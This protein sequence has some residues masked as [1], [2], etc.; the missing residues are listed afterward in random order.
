MA[1]VASGCMTGEAPYDPVRAFRAFGFLVLRRFF[2]PGPV[3]DE[4]DAVLP[5]IVA[6]RSES[7]GIR[8]QYV[9]MMTERTP[10]SLALLDR[11]D[12]VAATLLGGAV[13]PTRAKGARYWG[14]TPW[15]TDSDAP[16][17]SIGFLAYLDPLDAETGALRV[18]PGS[19][20]PGYAEAIRNLAAG[21]DL[22]LES[23]GVVLPSKPG[24]LIVLE[25]RLWHASFGGNVRRQ[26]RVDFLRV[27]VDEETDR[28]TRQ[29]FADLYRPDSV[30]RYDAARHPSYGSAWKR[31]SRPAVAQLAA[32]GAYELAEAQE[33]RRSSL[34]FDRELAC[35]RCWSL[36]HC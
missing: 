15:H 4:L 6:A 14:D 33:A 25:E 20:C 7:G 24:D 19:Q 22:Q 34:R 16:L 5:D 27:P 17:A 2:D 26:W 11:S 28:L 8:F 35:G 3:A 13:L 36:S 29:Y 32:L 10:A 9:P 30:V 31:S 12:V 18:L 1:G 21:G 23:S